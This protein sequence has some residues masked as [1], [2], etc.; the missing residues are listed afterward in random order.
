[1]FEDQKFN[2]N[3]SC[4]ECAESWECYFF[5]LIRRKPEI[6]SESFIDINIIDS[7]APVVY[8]THSV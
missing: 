2:F 6:D 8:F 7:T 4:A 1:M 5:I 3:V